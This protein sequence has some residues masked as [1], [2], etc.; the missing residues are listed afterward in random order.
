MVVGSAFGIGFIIGPLITIAI[1]VTTGDSYALVALVAACYALLAM[2]VTWKMLPETRAERAPTQ[3]ASVT[4]A[5]TQPR[6]WFNPRIGLLLAALALQQFAFGGFERLLSL[7]NLTTLGIGA[8][9]TGYLFIYIGLIVVWVQAR[10]IK[11]F[12]PRVG[13][14]RLAA[15]GFLALAVGLCLLSLTPAVPSPWFDR[16]ALQAALN[17]SNATLLANPITAALQINLPSGAPGWAGLGWLLIALVPVSLG[18]AVL[19][20]VLNSLLSQQVAPQHTGAV[21]GVSSSVISAM[22]AAAPLIGG[23]LFGLNPSYPFVLG[24]TAAVV[25]FAAFVGL[26]RWQAALKP[27]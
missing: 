25:G 19:R 15:D 13:E 11:Q 23:L 2:F 20:P 1:L 26:A 7:F 18:G 16:A 27:T 4:S 22:N 9:G 3:A 24:A 21:L 5:T 8:T 14:R 17:G 10:A 12:A 6:T